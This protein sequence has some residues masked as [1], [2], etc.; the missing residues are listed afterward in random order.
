MVLHVPSNRWVGRVKLPGIPTAMAQDGTRLW[1]GMLGD[2]HLVMEFMKEDLTGSPENEWVDDL[3]DEDE[4]RAARSALTRSEQAS[5]AFF[6][7]DYGTVARLLAD[8]PTE[9]LTL[10]ERFLLAF[11]FDAAGLNRPDEARQHLEMI[12]QMEPHSHWRHEAEQALN[13]LEPAA[14]RD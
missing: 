13:S 11:S 10:G 9:D 8:V 12:L 3:P 6:E 5:Y 7:R 4:V 2:Q 14:A 1:I